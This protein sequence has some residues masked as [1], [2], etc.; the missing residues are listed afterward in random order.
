MYFESTLLIFLAKFYVDIYV[1]RKALEATVGS[2]VFESKNCYL[3]KV[4]FQNEFLMF[5]NWWPIQ[6][7][8]NVVYE[9]S[10]EVEKDTVIVDLLWWV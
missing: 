4:C 8:D 2:K 9:D 3:L 1:I 5:P 6:F 7:T 10:M